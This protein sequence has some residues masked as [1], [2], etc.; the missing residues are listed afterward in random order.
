MNTAT[1]TIELV[2]E[3]PAL[4]TMPRADLPAIWEDYRAKLEKLKATAETLTVTDVSQKA[5]MKLARTTR[6]LLKDLRVDVEKRRKEL[7]EAALRTKQKIDEQAKTI[8]ELI[9]PLEARLLEQEQFAEALEAKAK[10]ETRLARVELISPFGDPKFYSL[11]DMTPEAFDTLLAGLKASKA[12]K[13]EEDRKAKEAAEAKAKAEAEERER[14]RLEN[15][16][17]KAEAAEKEK[18]L[19]AERERVAKEQAEAAAKAAA[20]AKKQREELEAK[21]KAEREAL[22]A[23]AKVEREAAAQK[24]KEQAEAERAERAKEQAL[25][26]AAEAVAREEQ[27]ARAKA[28]AELKAKADAE[29]AAR[30]AAA[31]AAKKAAAAPDKE[32]IAAFAATVRALVAPVCKTPEGEKVSGL[33]GEQIEKFSTWA[34]KQAEQL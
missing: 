7:G 16:R 24:S 30:K 5:E 10:E 26:E 23:Q 11:A 25:R 14:V 13:E 19:K 18:E 1:E 27:A 12:A 22:E 4:E 34:Q 8:K 17:L 20:E 15:E 21:A 9:E 29:E 32:K 33:I 3:T 28:E 6:L 31:A 2:T